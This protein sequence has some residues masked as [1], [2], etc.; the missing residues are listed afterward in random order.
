MHFPSKT[1]NARR[2]GR[3]L[4]TAVALTGLAGCAQTGLLEG[5]G[6]GLASSQSADARVTPKKTSDPNDL[7][8]ATAYWGQQ[9]AKDPKN[10]QLA[11]NY[12][13]N[14]RAIGDK[15]RAMA[16]LQN[17]QRLNPSNRELAAEL[18][19][20]A[21]ENGRL[22]TAE[23]LLAHASNAADWKTLSAKGALEAQRGNYKTAQRLFNQALEIVPGKTSVLNNLALAYA[24]DG[25]AEKAEVL[26]RQVVDSG[27]ATPKIRQNLALVLGLQGK[28][29]EAREITAADLPV[30]L[31]SANEAYMRKMLKLRPNASK[32]ARAVPVKSLSKKALAAAIAGTWQTD[33]KTDLRTA[34]AANPV[35]LLPAGR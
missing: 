6:T 12:A 1:R 2:Y 32:T 30:K 35:N 19:R 11:L 16:V 15:K 22:K 3:L 14:L 13:R 17:A 31:A 29:D 26:L 21:L 24:L 27:R 7:P 34:D 8:R 18:G 20:V 25:Q 5:L 23:K 10:P 33:V 9:Y 28:F 4:A